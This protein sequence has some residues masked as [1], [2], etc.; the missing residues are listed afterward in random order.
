MYKDTNHL[1]QEIR[2]NYDTV[3]VREN[4]YARKEI[5]VK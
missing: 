2:Q 5:P 1:S 3:A 4:K